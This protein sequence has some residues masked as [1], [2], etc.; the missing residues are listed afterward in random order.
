MAISF[1]LLKKRVIG[2]VSYR[3]AKMK[4]SNNSRLLIAI[5]DGRRGCI[6][7]KKERMQ[8]VSPSD[9]VTL[10][11]SDVNRVIINMHEKSYR[12]YDEQNLRLHWIDYALVIT[13]FVN[14]MPK[15]VLI[16]AGVRTKFLDLLCLL[17]KTRAL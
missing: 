1:P 12:R 7:M 17:I 16:P 2:G 14:G 5:P 8:G 10:S 9:T 13:K 6:M 3:T 15:A 4:I 11:A